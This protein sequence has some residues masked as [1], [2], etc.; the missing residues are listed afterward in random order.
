MWIEWDEKAR[1]DVRRLTEFY[2]DGGDRADK[3]NPLIPSIPVC[4]YAGSRRKDDGIFTGMK[5]MKG[6][7]LIPS[8]PFIPVK[9]SNRT[10]AAFAI[11]HFQMCPSFPELREESLC[12]GRHQVSDTFGSAG[13]G[14]HPEHSFDHQHVMISPE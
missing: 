8:I 12:D 6:I 14:F 9:I 7:F 13:S 5:G 3:T 4:L 11:A 10:P 2:R 1:I